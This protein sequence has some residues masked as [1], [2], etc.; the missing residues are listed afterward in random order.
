MAQ[1]L[2]KKCQNVTKTIIK[3]VGQCTHMN[4]NHVHNCVKRIRNRVHDPFS[5]YFGLGAALQKRLG[6]VAY[7]YMLILAKN[8]KNGQKRSL[9]IC[10]ME[11]EINSKSCIFE[12]GIFQNRVYAPS[13]NFFGLSFPT[14]NNLGGV[15]CEEMLK[16]AKNVKNGQNKAQRYVQLSSK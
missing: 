11:F 16:M 14:Q 12:W 5:N 13:S 1:I 7:Q 2:I 8:V 6:G 10:T 4:S 15:T 9:K 3:K